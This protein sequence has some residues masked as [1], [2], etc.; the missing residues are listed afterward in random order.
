[1]ISFARAALPLALAASLLAPPPALATGKTS[2]VLGIGMSFGHRVTPELYTGL[3]HSNTNADGKVSGAKALFYWD[4]AQSLAPSK[5]KVMGIIGGKTNWQPEIGAG[6]SFENRNGLFSAGVN[7]H[8]VAG[9][10]DFSPTT[11][12]APYVQIHT[13]GDY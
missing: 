12:L 8:H 9:G 2:L 5:F 11:G 10:V 7:S 13:G 3:E 1:M 6:Y 4:F